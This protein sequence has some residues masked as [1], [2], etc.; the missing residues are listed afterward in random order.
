MGAIK[1]H[2]NLPLLYDLAKNRKDLCI[3]L[4]GPIR[5]NHKEIH[6]IIRKL[7][8]LENVFRWHG[9]FRKCTEL[10]FTFNIGLMPYKRN[11]YTKNIYH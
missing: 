8:S 2:L 5:E 9:K 6:G 1:R 11:A 7:Q 3:V 4:V 10:S